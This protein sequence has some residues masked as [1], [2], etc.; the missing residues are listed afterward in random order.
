MAGKL[1]NG[2]HE[3]CWVA[4]WAALGTCASATSF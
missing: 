3:P 4:K 2:C 1:C